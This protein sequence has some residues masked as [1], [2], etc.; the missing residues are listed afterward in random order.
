MRELGKRDIREDRETTS[1]FH[2]FTKGFPELGA[3][4][5]CA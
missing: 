2:A 3:D 4:M 5:L 1:I